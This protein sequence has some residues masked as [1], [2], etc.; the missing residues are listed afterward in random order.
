MYREYQHKLDAN[1]EQEPNCVCLKDCC[2]LEWSQ[3]GYACSLEAEF[4]YF[5]QSAEEGQYVEG[6]DQVSVHVQPN[7]V[8]VDI[9]DYEYKVEEMHRDYQYVANNQQQVHY[10]NIYKFNSNK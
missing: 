3:V 5:F 7:H 6:D 4:V 1:S 2:A 9:V 8:L 10:K